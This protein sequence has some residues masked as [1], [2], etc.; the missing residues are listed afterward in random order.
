MIQME[1]SP[2]VPLAVGSAAGLL[3]VAVFVVSAVVTGRVRKR[4]RKDNARSRR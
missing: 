1:I 3:F 2:V 4:L